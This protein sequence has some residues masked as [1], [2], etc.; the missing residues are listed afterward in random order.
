[1]RKRAQAFLKARIWIRSLLRRYLSGEFLDYR[2]VI[3]IILP[4]IVDQA[5]VFGSNLINTAMI[6]SAGVAAVSAVNMVDSVNIFLVSV[7]VAVSTGG[8]VVVAQYKGRGNHAMVSKA[9]AGSVTSVFAFAFGIS[10]LFV[11]LHGPV[12]GFL[13]GRAAPDV[14]TNARI[15]L[16]GSGLSYCGI[17][18]EESV[19]GALRGVGEARS[20]L[21]LSLIM[22]L[23]YVGFNLIFINVL[24]L[25]VLGMAISI[26]LSR[27]LGAACALF[28]LM[29]VNISLHFCGR[30][31]FHV[32]FAMARQILFIGLPFAAEQ[33]FFNGG[34]ILTQIFIVGLG[35]YAIAVNAICNAVLGVTQ[36]PGSALLLS[37]VTVAGQCMGYGSLKD[38][39][40]FIRSFM[41]LTAGSYVLT[42][43]LMIPILS[44][45]PALFHPPASILP[46]IAWIMFITAL[47]QIPAW[48]PS[49][50][51]PSALRA[52][53]DAR[54]TS[55][56]SMLSMWLFRLGMGILLG[57]VLKLGIAGFWFAMDAEWFVRGV[58]FLWRFR[59]EK[60]YAHSVIE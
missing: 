17:A 12:L 44:F 15:Y 26:N 56:V 55:V 6:S 37:I 57:F 50:V 51:L 3:A 11:L 2:Q 14:M 38:T 16:I 25:G 24:H 7:F 29:R 53:G 47:A 19:C 20:A 18:L 59:G 1:M 54:F 22:N 32:S 28:Y 27:Y 30:D 42:A 10:L 21:S 31:V 8:T 13:F 45:M 34:K 36:I 23:S 48:A 9:T 39:K 52:A 35:T 60:W 46:T 5:F 43:L 41:W 58:V 40:K 33:M 4:I 49:F